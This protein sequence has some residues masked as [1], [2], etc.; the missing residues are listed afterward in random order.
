MNT[1]IFVLVLTG[2]AS[3]FLAKV[4]R[5]KDRR[6]AHG[7]GRGNRLQPLHTGQNLEQG[8]LTGPDFY[9][10]DQPNAH[11]LMYP[12]TQLLHVRTNSIL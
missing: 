1:E 8:A 4:A 10:L 9:K 6:R 11:T 5:T 12:F 2:M 7:G 3:V